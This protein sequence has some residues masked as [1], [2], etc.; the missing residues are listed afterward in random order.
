LRLRSATF[1][2]AGHQNHVGRFNGHVGAGAKADIGLG[3]RGRIVDAVA[4]EGQPTVLGFQA[5]DRIHLAVG[6]DLGHDLVDA[7]ASRDGLGRAA[8]V[9]GDHRDLQPQIMQRL[10]VGQLQFGLLC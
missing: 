7:K 10:D 1:Q 3:E 5:L 9:A 8:V 2:A 4:H 6:E